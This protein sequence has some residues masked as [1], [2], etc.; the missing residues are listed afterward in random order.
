MD[1]IRGSNTS[2]QPPPSVRPGPR[3]LRHREGEALSG[4]G[5]PSPS[6]IPR[7]PVMG[8][9]LQGRCPGHGDPGPPRQHGDG[10]ER[11][12]QR[13]APT[14][15]PPANSAPLPFL[16]TPPSPGWYVPERGAGWETRRVSYCRGGGKRCDCHQ[17]PAGGGCGEAGR[18][19]SRIAARDKT[20]CR[21]SPS[22]GTSR[23]PCG[24]APPATATATAA[25]A[26]PGREGSR[27]CT[28]CRFHPGPSAR[29]RL[30]PRGARGGARG[31]LVKLGVGK[32]IAGMVSSVLVAIW[33]L[34]CGGRVV[35]GG[36][37]KASG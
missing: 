10:Q 34:G 13:P 14:R 6:A 30:L 12:Q 4:S 21:P 17:C 33:V 26:L 16:P 3:W 23:L 1:Y 22:L 11:V 8:T 20:R 24:P 7:V 5:T 31:W 28:P 37:G 29:S 18:W 2:P 9:A 15:N 35:S 19:R 36:L 32:V 27:C 25:A